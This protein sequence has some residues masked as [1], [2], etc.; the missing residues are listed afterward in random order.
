MTANAEVWVWS[1]LKSVV[2]FACSIVPHCKKDPSYVFPDMKQRKS[3]TP[4]HECRNWKRG[5]A[6]SFLG[7]FVSNFWYTVFA[8]HC[9]I[10]IC[11]PPDLLLKSQGNEATEAFH[12]DDQSPFIY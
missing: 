2:Y 9:K 8:V 7:I 1:Q 5:R 3:L 12:V 4:I 6:V 10:F 11:A